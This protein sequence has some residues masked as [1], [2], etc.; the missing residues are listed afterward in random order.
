MIEHNGKKFSR[1]QVEGSEDEFFMDEN[2]GLYD[3]NFEY[4]NTNI[5]DAAI[6]EEEN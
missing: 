1:I 4:L 6:I 5:G 3:L 2:G